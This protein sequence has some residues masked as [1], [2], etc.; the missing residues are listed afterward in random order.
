MCV[1]IILM[2]YVSMCQKEFKIFV[3]KIY[4]SLTGR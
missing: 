3:I 2:E 4:L 1:K